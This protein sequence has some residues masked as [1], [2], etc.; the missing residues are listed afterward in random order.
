MY[1]YI[2]CFQTACI[3]VSGICLYLAVT[4]EKLRKKKYGL[5]LIAVLA[6]I[7]LAE[8]GYGLYLQEITMG[9]LQAAEKFCL[10]GKLGAVVGFFV[11]CVSLSDKDSAAVKMAAG[12]L[13]LTCVSFLFFDSL[14]GFLYTE[15]NFLQNQFFY[16]IEAQRTGLGEVLYTVTRCIPLLGVLWLVLLKKGR[17]LPEKMLASAALLLWAVSRICG[18]LTFLRHYDGD[19]PVFAAFAVCLVIF[20]AWKERENA[21]AGAADDKIW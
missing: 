10:M 3:I 14:H 17:C 18:K 21:P 2:L 5:P 4:D 19:M 8:I 13:G 15:Q 6:G 16:Y 12:I 1:L 7:C 20:A 9:G 11:T